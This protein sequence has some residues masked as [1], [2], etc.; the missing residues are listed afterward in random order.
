MDRAGVP[1]V[2]DDGDRFGQALAVGDFDADGFDDLAIGVPNDRISGHDD[3]GRVVVLFG[4]VSGLTTAGARGLHQNVSGIIGGA[5]DGDQFGFSLTT[6]DFDGDGHD[7]LAIGVAFEDIGSVMDAGGVAVIFGTDAGFGTRD[8]FFSENSSGIQ[9]KSEAFDNM[10]W[11]LAAGDFDGDGRDDLAIGVPNE[12]FSNFRFDAGQVNVIFGAAGGFTT[13]GDEL[14]HQDSSGILDSV[15]AFDNFGQALAAGDFD[16]DGRDDLAIGVP[17]EDFGVSR[18]DAGMVNV[19]YGTSSGLDDARTQRFHQDVGGIADVAQAFDNFGASLAAGDF[20]GNGRDDLA[21]GVPNE[22]LGAGVDAGAVAV[23]YASD[24]GRL[25]TGAN[26]FWHQN[27]PGFEADPF[28]FDDFG[29]SVTSADFDGD[30]MAE[31]VIGTPGDDVDG[32]GGAGSVEVL[33]GDAD[34]L[35]T[36]NR[37]QRWHQNR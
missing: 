23:L 9:G 13:I 15:E 10:G 2:S 22:D 4:S 5:E 20:D 18:M 34:G 14:W 24:T 8:R 25:G 33:A 11:S 16:G 7:D 17:N 6:G 27:L 28:A 31:L 37:I 36:A 32:K 29:R 1:G 3:A 26:E 35:Q 19:L 12:D 21:I 30:G